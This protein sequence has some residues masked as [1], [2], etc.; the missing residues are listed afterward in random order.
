MSC[1][2]S[3]LAALGR[4]CTPQMGGIKYVY[5]CALPANGKIADYSQNDKLFFRAG[6]DDDLPGIRGFGFFGNN[7]NGVIT[8]IAGLEDQVGYPPRIDTQIYRIA[9]TRQQAVITSEAQVNRETGVTF[10]QNAVTI[11]TAALTQEATKLVSDL[12][13]GGVVVIG[14]SYDGRFCAFGFQERATLNAA[15]LTTGAAFGDQPGVTITLMAEES[16]PVLVG[17]HLLDDEGLFLDATGIENFFR[18]IVTTA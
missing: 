3:N 11:P 8:T 10:Y 5:L 1:T 6:T 14:E 4:P 2:P 15:S 17:M 16:D 9:V 18:E 13:Y 7:D 12:A